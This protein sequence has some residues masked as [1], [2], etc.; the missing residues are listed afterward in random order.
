MIERGH[1]RKDQ[2]TY[3]RAP[4][5]MPQRGA[6]ENGRRLRKKP[7]QKAVSETEA[8][9]NPG[10]A[11]WLLKEPAE[12]QAGC[13]TQRQQLSNCRSIE[14]H[15]QILLNEDAMPASSLAEL[16][17]AISS[18]AD[19]AAPRNRGRTSQTAQQRACAHQPEK[20]DSKKILRGVR[21]PS[22]PLRPESTILHE[23]SIPMHAKRMMAPQR[24]TCCTFR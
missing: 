10:K 16:G 4:G 17:T 2:R 14:K 11:S 22:A 19:P 6:H 9:A 21:S 8:E 12:K 23:M 20:N 7:L 24:H 1:T 3:S 5:V 13:A 18:Q 15:F